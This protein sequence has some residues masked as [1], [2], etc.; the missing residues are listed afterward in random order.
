MSE[1]PSGTPEE[2][3]VLSNDSSQQLFS[4]AK[5]LDVDVIDKSSL[6]LCMKLL[7]EGIDPQRLAHSVKKIKHETSQVI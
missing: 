5:L 3:G 2:F 1:Q 7:D 4:I 6:R